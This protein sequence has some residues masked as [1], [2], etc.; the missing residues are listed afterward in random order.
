MY[1]SINKRYMK[2]IDTDIVSNGERYFVI[3]ENYWDG[4]K[5]Y[6]C[7]EISKNLIDIIDK[8]IRYEIA[9]IHTIDADCVTYTIIR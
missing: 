8:S 3:S 4:D 7:F 6:N 9:P 5:Y 2:D 1:K